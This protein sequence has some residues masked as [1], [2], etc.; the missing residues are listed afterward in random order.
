MKKNRLR[1]VTR[2]AKPLTDEQLRAE[3]ERVKKKYTKEFK[4]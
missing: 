3:L 1:P 2:K 4:L